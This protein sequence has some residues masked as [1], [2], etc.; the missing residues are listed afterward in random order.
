MRHSIGPLTLPARARS[1]RLDDEEPPVRRAA[2]VLLTAALTPEAGRARPAGV[3]RRHR[4]A[5]PDDHGDRPRPGPA[6][7]DMAYRGSTRQPAGHAHDRARAQPAADGAGHRLSGSGR[8]SRCGR[9]D[10]LADPVDDLGRGR[11]GRE[12]VGDAEPLELGDV[13]VGDDPAAEDDDVVDPALAHAARRAGRTASCGRR[14]APTGRRRRR[15]PGRRSRRSAPASG[16][17]RCRRPPCRR[18]A[19]PAPRPW[20]RGRARRGP[21]WR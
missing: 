20:R 14:R 13:L 11:A 3:R 17:G 9:A 12:D 15:P 8:R 18:R 2:T 16:A 21:A 19:A 5:R 7:G 10:V 4:A 6:G 1:T